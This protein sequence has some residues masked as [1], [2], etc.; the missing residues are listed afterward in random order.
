[1][2]EAGP[3]R[4]GGGSEVAAKSLLV[5][6]R[7]DVFD[8]DDRRRPLRFRL[9]PVDRWLPIPWMKLL[10][11]RF[12]DHTGNAPHH[13]R[14]RKRAGRKV[15]ARPE[16]EHVESVV[17]GTHGMR[18]VEVLVHD[19]VA[20]ADLVGLAVHPRQ[21]RTG[22]HVENLLRLAVR[23]R[24]SRLLA[25]LHLDALHARSIG[26]CR[27]AE[28]APGCA[29]VSAFSATFRDVVPMRD[30]HAVT[31]SHGLNERGVATLDGFACT[32]VAV[33]AGPCLGVADEPAQ[34]LEHY[35]GGSAVTLEHFDPLEPVDHCAGLVH[36]TTVAR[37]NGRDRAAFVPNRRSDP[38]RAERDRRRTRKAERSDRG[39]T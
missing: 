38:R 10:E 28:V 31:L 6:L 26:P 33:D 1:M 19:A 35:S 9:R 3:A 30:S 22:E 16:R 2:S 14:A 24:G 23:V 32:L 21:T 4:A 27:R 39:S 13:S 5:G 29:D 34:L 37:Q 36:A 7:F 8:V 12:L 20:G 18:L 25:G 15:F 17:A 11:R